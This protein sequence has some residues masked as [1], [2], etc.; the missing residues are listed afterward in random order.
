VNDVAADILASSVATLFAVLGI[1]L[2][3][4]TLP[5]TWLAILVAT[6][7][8]AWRG[9]LYSWWTLIICAFIALVGEV[10][11]LAAS[12][13][14]AAKGGAS[15]KGALAAVVGSL[16]G[17]V[18]GSLFLPPIGTIMGAVLGAG[19]AA[20][21]VEHSLLQRPLSEAAKA[22]TG[23]AAGRLIATLAKAGLSAV[24]AAI[25]ITGAWLS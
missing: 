6:G 9:D 25:L 1:A 24:V 3:L 12:A 19:L 16:V 5:G 15:R 11:E 23:A 8:Q 10:V 4:L 18:V 13:L 7:L 21:W 17:A 14:G 20:L 2:T 22:G